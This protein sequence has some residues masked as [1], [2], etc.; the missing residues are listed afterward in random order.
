MMRKECEYQYLSET[1][2]LYAFIT[3]ENNDWNGRYLW[4]LMLVGTTGF[5]EYT[6]SIAGVPQ[7]NCLSAKDSQPLPLSFFLYGLAR[8]LI[9]QEVMFKDNTF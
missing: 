8:S 9:R 7:H 5:R 4:F 2:V 3:K 6:V 1:F